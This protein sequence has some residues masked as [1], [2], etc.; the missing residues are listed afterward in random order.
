MLNNTVSN[1]L[2]FA[3]CALLFL[4]YQKGLKDGRRRR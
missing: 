3:F 2:I 1:L 4:A